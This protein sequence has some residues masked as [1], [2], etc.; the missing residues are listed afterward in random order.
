MYDFTR[1][2][3]SLERAK[4]VL[5]YEPQDNSVKWEDGERISE[6]SYDGLYR[7][8]CHRSVVPPL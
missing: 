1:K 3:D 2:C 7:P 8:G 5:G 6:E 4:A